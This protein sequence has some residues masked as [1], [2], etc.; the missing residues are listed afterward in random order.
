MLGPSVGLVL[1]DNPFSAFWSCADGSR[2]EERGDEDGEGI[3]TRR[4]GWERWCIAGFAPSN[5]LE[6]ESKGQSFV[7]RRLS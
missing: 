1:P 6:V 5:W 3:P 2:S 4:D 7:L